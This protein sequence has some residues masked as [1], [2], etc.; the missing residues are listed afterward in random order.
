MT[1]EKIMKNDDCGEIVPVFAS[2]ANIYWDA[3]KKEYYAVLIINHRL[4]ELEEK[5]K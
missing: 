1:E 2:R 4:I 5:K 3:D